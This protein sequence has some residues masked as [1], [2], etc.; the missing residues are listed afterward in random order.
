MRAAIFP[1]RISVTHERQYRP[2]VDRIYDSQIRAFFREKSNENLSIK[3]ANWKMSYQSKRKF[4]DSC[5]YLNTVSQTR[6]IEIGKKLI[7]NYQ[8]SFITLTLPVAQFTDDL[9]IK[10]CLNQFLTQLRMKFGLKNYVWKAELQKNESIHFHLIIDIPIHHKAIRYYWNQSLEVL[11]YVSAF[12]SKFQKMSLKE[13]ADHRGI[14]IQDAVRPFRAGVTTK[15]RNPPTEQIK[16]VRN[17]KQL[18]GYLSKYIVKPL[19]E[20]E[21]TITQD[22]IDRI[23]SFG[24]F[25]GRSHSLSSIVYFNYYDWDALREFLGNCEKTLFRKVYEWSQI[26]YV[27]TATSPRLVGW[28]KLKMLELGVTFQYPFPVF[29]KELNNIKTVY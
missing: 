12:Q 23:H 29:P 8:S 14:S 17:Y 5:N 19:K 13:Y 6:T 24:R 22:E 18:A 28:I 9:S 2:V 7:Y 21:E 1:N 20:Q 10:G 26:L 3:K 25:W 15:W 4:L 11:G 27:S 16:M